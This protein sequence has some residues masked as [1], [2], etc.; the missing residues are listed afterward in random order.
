MNEREYRDYVLAEC[1]RQWKEN[2]EEIHGPWEEVPE[3]IKE[4]YFDEMYSLLS[5]NLIKACE[6]CSYSVNTK[7][8]YVCTNHCSKKFEKV[9]K[10]DYYCDEFS[11][12]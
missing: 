11:S 8:G 9:V 7:N 5:D 12:C 10:D 1:K 3:S 2:Q 6:D 4:D